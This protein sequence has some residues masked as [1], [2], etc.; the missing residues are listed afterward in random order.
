ML[1]VTTRKL[2][3]GTRTIACTFSAFTTLYSIFAASCALCGA[4]EKTRRK[5]TLRMLLA[6]VYVRHAKIR[7]YCVVVSK[8]LSKRVRVLSSC[9][10]KCSTAWKFVFHTLNTTFPSELCFFK[11]HTYRL[12]STDFI[13][14]KVA[15]VP[16]A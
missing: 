16:S 8:A 7:H 10:S 13:Y 1:R 2:S 5:S 14:T 12:T 9:V 11:K 4:V 6:C 3:A 15:Q